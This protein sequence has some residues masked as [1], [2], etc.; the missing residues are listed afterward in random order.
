MAYWR[1]FYHVVWAT[2][3]RQPL[4]TPDLEP[5]LH[6]YLAGKTN[7]LGGILHAVGNTSDHVHL[8][9]SIPPRMAVAAFVGALKGSSSYHINHLPGS[10]R[11]FAWQGEYGVMSLGERSLQTVIEYVHGQKHHHKEHRLWAILERVADED[12]VAQ[13][14]AC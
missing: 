14:Q 8:V 10:E 2:H 7:A 12:S 11:N 5:E 6:R 4:L 3:E 9:I 1:L 13:A